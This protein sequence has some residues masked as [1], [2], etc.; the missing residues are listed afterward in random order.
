MESEPLLLASLVLDA[1]TANIKKCDWSGIQ[2]IEAISSIMKKNLKWQ[3]YPFAKSRI[4]L[5]SGIML[6]FISSTF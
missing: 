2:M 4:L 3:S 5:E 6:E 1:V